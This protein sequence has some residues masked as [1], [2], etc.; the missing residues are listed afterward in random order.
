V[1]PRFIAMPTHAPMPTGLRTP[2]V[3]PSVIRAHL[4]DLSR[5]CEVSSFT[6]SSYLQFRPGGGRTR[7]N[8]SMKLRQGLEQRHYGQAVRLEVSRCSEYLSAFLP[9][10]WF[11]RFGAGTA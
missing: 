6:I 2:F 7:C 11:A 4:N 8:A 1:L 5:P 9:S 3:S 10:N